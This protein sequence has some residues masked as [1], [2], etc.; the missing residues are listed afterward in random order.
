MDGV[1]LPSFHH[2][3]ECVQHDSR[4]ADSLAAVVSKKSNH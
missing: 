4:A 3:M 2:H 1:P